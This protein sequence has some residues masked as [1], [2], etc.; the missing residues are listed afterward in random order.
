MTD[1]DELEKL[2]LAAT[3]GPWWVAGKATIRYGTK[4]KL[5]SGWIASMH[6]REAAANGRYIAAASPDAVL[7]LVAIAR[8][9]VAP[10]VA[11]LPGMAVQGALQAVLDA[12]EDGDIPAAVSIVKTLKA[13]K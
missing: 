5:D 12:L 10:M 3:P 11:D 8:A 6:W 7:R 13:R 1:L 4:G 2:A 9:N